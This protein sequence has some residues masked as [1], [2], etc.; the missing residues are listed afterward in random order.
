MKP[1]W[2]K[3]IEEANNYD[4]VGNGLVCSQHFLDEDIYTVGSQ[5]QLRKGSIPS[6]FLVDVMEDTPESCDK[7]DENK[8]DKEYFHKLYLKLSLDSQVNEAKLNHKLEKLESTLNEKN[9]EILQLKKRVGEI[10]KLKNKNKTLE[11]ELLILKTSPD[12]NVG[13]YFIQI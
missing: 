13:K 3:A 8:A 9:E 2:I 6:I 1:K 12:I 11:E 10:E 5:V 7:C 4:F